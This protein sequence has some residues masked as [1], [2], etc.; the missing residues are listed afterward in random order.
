MTNLLPFKSKRPCVSVVVPEQFKAPLVV[1]E[2]VILKPSAVV[3]ADIVK[4]EQLSV[5]PP[6]KLNVVKA[7]A[8]YISTE[9]V[10][11]DKPLGKDTV[12][13]AFDGDEFESNITLSDVVGTEAPEAPPEVVDHLEV[14]FQSP[15][16][17]TQ[18]RA[19]I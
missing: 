9:V 11:A 12:K 19:A 17:P 6:L 1:V 18:Y 8:V 14:L 3:V 5:P 7:L 4:E 16:P 13:S 2:S 10:L 15:V